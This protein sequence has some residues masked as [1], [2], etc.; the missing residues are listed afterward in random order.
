MAVSGLVALVASAYVTAAYHLG[1]PE[2]RSKRVLLPVA[3]NTIITFGMLVTGN[4]LAA[5]VSHA[6]MH[7]A[8]V[9]HGAEATV[10]LPPHYEE[11]HYAPAPATGT[12]AGTA[13]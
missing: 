9:I 13:A 7:I 5:I 4:P 10:Q 3:G 11:P 12:E 6:I 2:F 8:A 1:Y